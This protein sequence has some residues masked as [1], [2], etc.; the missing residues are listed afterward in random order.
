MANDQTCSREDAPDTSSWPSSQLMDENSRLRSE[1]EELRHRVASL[2]SELDHLKVEFEGLSYAANHDDLTGVFTR[3]AAVSLIEQALVSS[4]GPFI[5]AF[6]DVDNFKACNDTYGHLVGDEVLVALGHALK[7]RAHGHGVVGRFGG[8][9][10][11]FFLDLEEEMRLNANLHLPNL[12]QPIKSKG[13]L[14][15]FA[16]NIRTQAFEDI[17][18]SLHIEGY[19]PSVSLGVVL[20]RRATSVD[21][22]IHVADAALYQSKEQGRN[23]ITLVEA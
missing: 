12:D 2:Q 8:D 4:A 18:G 17:N 16:D 6:I 7:K 20:A 19:R 13:M 21:A 15:Q 10:F 9:E 14:Y 3:Q 1:N 22:L 23:G 5:L 11:L